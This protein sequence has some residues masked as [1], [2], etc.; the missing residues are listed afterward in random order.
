MPQ[1][2]TQGKHQWHHST[3]K[4]AI[5]HVDAPFGKHPG[6]RRCRIAGIVCTQGDCWFESL[7]EVQKCVVSG[8]IRVS[9][10]KGPRKQC[11]SGPSR[12]QP[13]NTSVAAR[14]P[15]AHARTRRLLRRPALVGFCTSV[16][17][18]LPSIITSESPCACR[19]ETT[20]SEL[21]CERFHGI[22]MY[23]PAREPC[24]G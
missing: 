24:N 6:K 1:A 7:A 18:G 23:T 9:C 22:P 8:A 13:R 17:K 16:D 10:A 4:P 19:C 11:V 5:P 20:S 14:N 21:P 12:C 3:T 2:H 15:H